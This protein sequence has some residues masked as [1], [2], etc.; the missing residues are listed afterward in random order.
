[1]QLRRRGIDRRQ[2]DGR[3]QESTANAL[4]DQIDQLLLV[5]KGKDLSINVDPDVTRRHGR[6]PGA[7]QDRRPG[8]VP[9]SAIREQTGM[10]YEDFRRPHE[11]PVC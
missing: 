1:M 11:E 7:E 6:D 2:A 3:R 4:R 9:R 8:Q 10:S 5:Q